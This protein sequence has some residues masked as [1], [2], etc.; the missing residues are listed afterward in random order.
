MTREIAPATDTPL[1]WIAPSNTWYDVD[2]PGMW[3]QRELL[4]LRVDRQLSWTEIASIQQASSDAETIKR[5]AARCRKQFE[6]TKE[7]LRTLAEAA[8]LLPA[9]E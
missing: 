6:R 5:E 2:L 1:V 7:K 8:G 4:L 9:K 3:H